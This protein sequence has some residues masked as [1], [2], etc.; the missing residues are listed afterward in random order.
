MSPSSSV[1]SFFKRLLPEHSD[2]VHGLYDR[3]PNRQQ[4]LLVLR[5]LRVPHAGPDHDAVFL[6]VT[7]EDFKAT[8][9]LLECERVLDAVA[10]FL[11]GSEHRCRLEQK[12]AV[13]DPQAAVTGRAD[14]ESGQAVLDLARLPDVADRRIDQRLD[15]PIRHLDAVP[16]QRSRFPIGHGFVTIRD[17]LIER[18]WFDDNRSPT[19]VKD[20]KSDR[21]VGF[22]R[23]LFQAD[24]PASL[25]DGL[26]VQHSSRGSDRLVTLDN[27]LLVCN[28][29]IQRQ[30]GI[31]DERRP[32]LLRVLRGIGDANEDHIVSRRAAGRCVRHGDDRTGR[33]LARKK[34]FTVGLRVGLEDPQSIENGVFV[35]G[36]FGRLN[37]DV[38]CSIAIGV[39]GVEPERSG[40]VFAQI[41][42]G[43][44]GHG[45]GAFDAQ[46]LHSP[47]GLVPPSLAQGKC[48]AA[49]TARRWVNAEMK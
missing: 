17:S 34:C 20:E 36:F 48:H 10:G 49:G 13:H 25:V 47:A 23:E 26:D 9:F 43:V 44:D 41:S 7:F 33:E 37:P 31:D 6:V 3:G 12:R 8:V 24:H 28:P 2:V 38:N 45:V 15:L 35:S 1:S 11:T 4:P 42:D 21:L 30:G 40:L 16:R 32:D 46:N 27:Q 5:E 22:N 19:A 39:L 14:L 29:V 18:L